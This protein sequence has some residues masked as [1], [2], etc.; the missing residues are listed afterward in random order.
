MKE[1]GPDADRVQVLFITVDPDRDTPEL[2]SKYVPAFDPRFLGLRGDLP[3]TQRAA[4]F[5]GELT[6]E[7]GVGTAVDFTLA[8]NNPAQGGVLVQGV[9]VDPST[10]KM[11]PNIPFTLKAAPAPGYVFSSWTGTSGGDA[12]NVT[13]TSAKTIT[14]NFVQSPLMLKPLGTPSS[15]PRPCE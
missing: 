6:T 4:N 1:L 5:A 7:L 10:F 3:A 14:A 12:I 9:P 2:L 15:Q 11:Y 13:I 8:V